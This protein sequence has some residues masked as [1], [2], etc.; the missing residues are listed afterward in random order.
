MRTTAPL[1]VPSVVL[2]TLLATCS[3][4]DGQTLTGDA[5]GIGFGNI[6]FV[7]Q[8][9]SGAPETT[10]RSVVVPLGIVQTAVQWARV[11]P[12]SGE[13]DLATLVQLASAPTHVV[14]GPPSSDGGARFLADVRQGTVAGDLT[15]Y[16]GFSPV[17]RLSRAGVY[18][19]RFGRAFALRPPSFLSHQL[20]LGGGPYLVG[21]VDA[22]IDPRFEQAIGG[23]SAA[24]AAALTLGGQARGEAAI[25]VSAGYSVQIPIERWGG[26]VYVGANYSH[27][28]GLR[29]E[30][31]DL[32]MQI[33]TDTEGLVAAATTV[34]PLAI[35][36]RRSSSGIG[37]TADISASAVFGAWRGGVRVDGL[38]NGMTW[39]SVTDRR[40]EMTHLRGAQALSPGT[41]RP[42]A[43]IRLRVPTQLRAHGAYVGTRWSAVGELERGVA[44]STTTALGVERSF[45]RAQVR[46]AG[47]LANGAVLPSAGVSVRFGKVWC[48]VAA[49][50]ASSSVEQRR[51]VILASSIRLTR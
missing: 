21:S 35:Q 4:G 19:P 51:H 24:R 20:Q 41:E 40:Y 6:D 43:D 48:D 3:S 26:E 25:Q 17:Q 32:A 29:L 23:A 22:Q 18:A 13:F 9:L 8:L 11:R 49:T 1:A 36:R 50:V 5:R 2:V 30:L 34:V 44:R 31:A 39:R 38:G 47:R 15:A 28:R 37:R 33:D 16:R 10:S 42:A 14:L 27:L 12:S 45:R 46:A 7:G